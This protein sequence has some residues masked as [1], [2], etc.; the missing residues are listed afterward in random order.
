[1]SKAEP[2]IPHGMP[3]PRFVPACAQLR[4]KTQYYRPEDQAQPPGLIADSDTLSYWCA[5]TQDHVGP[6][7]DGCDPRRCQIT[8][9]CYQAPGE[10]V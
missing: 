3:A 9:S 6:D 8:R 2:H 4:T 5:Q 10:L 1:M 7:L